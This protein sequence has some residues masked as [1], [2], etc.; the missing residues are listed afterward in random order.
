MGFNSSFSNF[1]QPSLKTPQLFRSKFNKPR[2]S[3]PAQALLLCF[4]RITAHKPGD[5]L[6]LRKPYSKTPGR[7]LRLD[8]KGAHTALDVYEIKL[9]AHMHDEEDL[10]MPPYR[11][12][13]RIPLGSA[14]EIVNTTS[15]SK[16]SVYSKKQ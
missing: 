14:S 3:C 1:T 10:M 11:D 12:R 6:K 15:C 16:M 4:A 7:L 5:H 2:F 8:L 13:A 9:L